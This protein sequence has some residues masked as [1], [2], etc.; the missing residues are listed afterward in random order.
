MKTATKHAKSKQHINSMKF[1]KKQLLMQ[2]QQILYPTDASF[3]NEVMNEPSSFEPSE[4]NNI[5]K[6]F[7]PGHTLKSLNE[8][9]NHGFDPESNAP[10]FYWSEHKLSGS[11]VRNLTAKAFS[12]HTEQ[13]SNAEARFSLTISQLL[14][15]LTESQR[16][17][18]AQCM[19]HAANSK[20]PQLSIFEHT[21]VPTSEDDFQKIYLSGPNAIVPNLPHPIP[22]TTADGTHAFV[23]L[24]DLLANELAKA[25]TFD[26]FFFESDVKFLPKDVTT[27]STT[28]SAYKLFLDLKEDD[29]EQYILYLWYKEWS[30][31][32]DPNNT[33]ASR[34]QVWCNT[35]TICP[36]DKESQGRN[37][38]FM[39]LSCKGEDHSEIEMEFQN[40]LKSLS[41][42]GKMF[43]HGGL[44]RII[45]VKMGKLLLCV[46]RPE[47][48]SI[49]Q[50]GDHN[51][52]YSTFWGHSCKVDGYCEENHLPSCK[53]CRKHRLHKMISEDHCESNENVLLPTSERE[54]D[55]DGDSRTENI[56]IQPCNGIKCAS[57]DV[58]HPSFTFTAPAHYP[59]EYDQRPGAPLPPKGR[60]LNLP[61]QGTKRILHTIRLNVK[62][63]K[64]ALIFGHHNVKTR[65]QGARTNKRIW[66][67]ANLSA[68]L[69]SCSC[70]G[71]LIDSVFTSAKI[72]DSDPPFP[73]AWSDELIFSKCHYA[74]MH[75]LFLGHV[76][77]DIYM[78]SK[79][80]GRYEILATFGKQANI[81]LHAIRSLR[82]NRF[83]AAH[84]FS[85]SSWG[86]GV[87]VSEN[88]LFW[89]RVMK[90]FLVLP[91]LNQ[92]R[93]IINNTKYIK[94]IRM[95]KR[96]VAAT[97][98]CLSRI[99]SSER[100]ASD[101]RDMILLYL[102]TMV[103]IDHLLLAPR[104]ILDDEQININENDDN[105]ME[106]LRAV[107]N[108]HMTTNVTKKIHPN[109]VKSNSLGLLVAAKTHSY[110]GPAKLNWEGGWHGERKIQK[111]KPLLHIKR[112]NADWPT[113]TLRRLYQHE[114]IQRLLN[115]CMSEEEK[116][117][118]ESR[119]MEDTVKVY[120]S[121]QMAEDVILQ[122]QPITAVLDHQNRLHI[123]FVPLVELIQP[124][125]LLTCW[126]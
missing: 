67:K 16:E 10:E 20:H 26:K 54:E 97:Q 122:N 17:L 90:F 29:D 49:L 80:L 91:A 84:P 58:M 45:K 126:R 2:E 101:L 87:W 81:Y 65:P 72:G 60:E 88:Y 113:I 105:T 51:G 98:A 79:W 75:M 102:D 52:T 7:L 37:S 99:M 92:Q 33:K 124:D 27:L 103:E 115:D 62:W 15:Q 57:W 43:Y 40:E 50:V 8:L 66:T 95:I 30:D 42:E 77:S 14:I 117:N 35:F 28:P 109:F 25:T 111:V 86:T 4:N 73:A 112:S 118:I 76:K 46:D 94:E 36:D 106:D 38:Y 125:L 19:L 11:G 68:Y 71:R 3:D 70:T 82:A 48:T 120:G 83:F 107:T 59:T 23:G 104:R 21:R 41:N 39:S 116:Q 22:K 89:G 96:F 44:K 108:E 55:S 18:F 74:P 114:T 47:R 5:P 1:W 93:L 63:L 110:H 64:S 31:D 119:E 78:V 123:P 32:F 24:T 12:L 121:R 69:R 85:T 56:F 61:I 6:T 100:V 53:E 9:K 13:V 34:N